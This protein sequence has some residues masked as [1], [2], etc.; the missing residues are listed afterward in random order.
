MLPLFSN[1]FLVRIIV[2]L[3]E[4]LI[5]CEESTDR[6]GIC[7]GMLDRWLGP[8]PKLMDGVGL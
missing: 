3:G 6:D 5:K 1:A 2:R 4:F 7:I 8:G